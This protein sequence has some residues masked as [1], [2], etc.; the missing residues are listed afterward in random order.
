MNGQ[1]VGCQGLGHAGC[2]LAP[3][4]VGPVLARLDDDLVA[5]AVVAEEEG[6]DLGRADLVQ[7]VG[8]EGLEPGRV[9]GAEVEVLQPLDLLLVAEGDGVEVVLEAGRERVVD[10]LVEVF[11]EQA[12]D[13]ER[14]PRRYERLALLPRGASRMVWMIVA[15]VD[16]RPMPSSSSRFTRLAS[17]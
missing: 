2:V 14:R 5:V 10:E 11:F 13:R 12:D 3:L 4:D 16:G 1:L 8:H 9:L 17:V 6:V 15:H 7:V